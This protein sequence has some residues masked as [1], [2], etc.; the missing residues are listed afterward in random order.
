VKLGVGHGTGGAKSAKGAVLRVLG[1]LRV[2]C[3][4]S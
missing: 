1:V 3:V 4:Q 2:R